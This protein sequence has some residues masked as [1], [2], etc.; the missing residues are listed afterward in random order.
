MYHLRMD[1]RLGHKG[2]GVGGLNTFYRP[3]LSYI[4]FCSCLNLKSKLKKN[5]VTHINTRMQLSH[6]QPTRDFLQFWKGA[7]GPFR[8]SLIGKFV[9]VHNC[10]FFCQTKNKLAITLLLPLQFEG[11]I[12]INGS[13]MSPCGLYG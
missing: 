3:N 8:L 10:D 2:D 5:K 4:I 1:S 13:R 12:R 11:K 9:T 7:L 6:K